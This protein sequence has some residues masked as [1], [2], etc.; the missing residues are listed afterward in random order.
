MDS[1]SWS[2]HPYLSLLINTDNITLTV[3]I[4]LKKHLLA[5]YI[6]YVNRKTCNWSSFRSISTYCKVYG[7]IPLLISYNRRHPCVSEMIPG[8]E[9][10]YILSLDIIVILTGNIDVCIC[11]TIVKLT[12][13]CYMFVI[14]CLNSGYFC[15]VVNI[16]GC[17]YARHSH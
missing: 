2:L 8:M 9:T 4:H 16:Y 15:S 5:L 17:I 14:L 1:L 13:T 12:F 10:T 6:V 7:L 3:I 11:I